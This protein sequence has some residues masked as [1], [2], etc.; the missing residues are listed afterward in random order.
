MSE[1]IEVCP[2]FSRLTAT[3]RRFLMLFLVGDPM[4][5]IA[6]EM[7]ISR[8]YASQIKKQILHK[9]ELVTEVGLVLYA[10]RF[11]LLG[12]HSC[13]CRKSAA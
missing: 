11:G 7:E 4:K 6:S 12:L 5:E 8:Q 10:V 2:L 13:A 9:L 3:E 1:P